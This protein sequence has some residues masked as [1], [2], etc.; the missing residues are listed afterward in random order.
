[1]RILLFGASPQSGRCGVSDYIQCLATALSAAGDD[2]QIPNTRSDEWHTNWGLGSCRRVLAYLRGSGAELVHVHYPS[3]NFGPRLLPWL[4]PLLAR[5]VRIPV[6]VTLHEPVGLLR[7][8][9]LLPVLLSGAALIT[10]RPNL[11]ELMGSVQRVLLRSRTLHYFRSAST[12][13]VAELSDVQRA[14]IRQELDCSGRLLVFFGFLYRA[15]GVHHLV[16]LPLAPGDVLAIA[17]ETPDDEYTDELR[18]AFR[19]RS[20]ESHVRFLGP[21][22]A[23]DASE[24]ISAADALLLPFEGG[25]G[26]WNTSIHAGIQNATFVI[27]TSRERSG[28]DADE[29]VFYVPPGDALAIIA[30]L[31]QR[32]DGSVSPAAP[33]A[34][35]LG[36]WQQL[37]LEH[38]DLYRQQSV[39]G[40]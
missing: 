26:D 9:R 20:L 16:E 8:Y 29:D 23:S 11:R 22:S 25:G 2:V 17:G 15:K 10:V 39:P 12:L 3:R 4:V 5:Y 37:A 33:T 27:T 36:R 1:M 14:T 38:Q 21:L 35:R 19:A 31:Q 6:V 13:P 32:V 28:Y 34:Q 30:A 40:A 24:L 7:L 18:A